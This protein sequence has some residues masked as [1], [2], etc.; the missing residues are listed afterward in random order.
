MIVRRERPGDQAQSRRVQSAAF[1][2]GDGEPVEATLLDELRV[3]DG[4]LPALSWVAEIS[5]QIVGHNVCTRGY[6]GTVSCVGLG[7]I[8]VAP[9]VQKSGVGSALM[10][11]MIGAA[12]AVGEP[13]IALLGN[14]AYYSQFGFVASS[15]LGVEPPDLAWGAYFQVLPL[16]SWRDSISGPFRYSAPF[17]EVS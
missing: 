6:V 15:D 13:L 12:D 4:W 3:C 8:G 5:G 1:D 16:T 9:D 11:A 17:D 7:P 10:H 14:P 2:K